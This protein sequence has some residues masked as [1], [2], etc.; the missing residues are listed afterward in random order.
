[1]DKLQQRKNELAAK[2]KALIDQNKENGNEWRDDAQRQEYETVCREYDSVVAEIEAARSQAEID[3]RAKALAEAENESVSQTPGG[4]GEQRQTQ[5]PQATEEHRK[6]ALQAWLLVGEG[7]DLTDEHKEACQLT[8]VNPRAN[9]FDFALQRGA[10]NQ[11]QWEGRGL[12]VGTSGAGQETIKQ[13]FSNE[14][15]RSLQAYG[16]PR[17]V[18]RILRTDGVG[19]VP[20]PSVDDTGNTGVRLAEATTIGASVDPTFSSVT[21]GAYKYSSK[22]ILVSA[23][24]LDDSAFNLGAEV[25]D[26]LGVRIGRITATEFTT[27]T[28]SSQPQGLA[29]GAS[30]GVTAASATAIDSDELFDLIHSL[31]PAYRSMRSVG[32]MMNDSTLLAIRKLQDGNGQ[33]LWQPGLQVGEPDRL[34]GYPIC[35]N[36]DMASIATG[37]VSVLFGAY[38]KYVIRDVSKVRAYRLEERY[39]DLDQ[40]GFVTFSRH[41][42]RYINTSAVKKL[43]QA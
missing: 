27:G 29:T 2:T 9:H 25:G 13:G 24:L 23:E 22:P 15:E 7:R 40:T 28:G 12:D 5:R 43:T 26:M 33:Y 30:A 3:A 36:Q 8:G 10:G 21:L 31:D 20:W 34:L 32:F 39:R 1:M 4:E 18:A 14:L 35:I 11:P 19:D 38:E 41:D 6:L 42:G 37:N 16:G 17:K